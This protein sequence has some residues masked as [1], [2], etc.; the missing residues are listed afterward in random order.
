[1]TL[2]L[3]LPSDAYFSSFLLKAE[4]LHGLVSPIRRPPLLAVAAEHRVRDFSPLASPLV[5]STV[6]LTKHLTLNI[7]WRIQSC[8]QGEERKV[9]L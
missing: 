5:P 3:V 1:M 7:T 8:C 2:A 6:W 9:G 4:P